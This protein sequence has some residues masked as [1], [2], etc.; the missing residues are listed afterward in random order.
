ME[1]MNHT[2]I[3]ST[4]FIFIASGEKEHNLT[5]RQIAAHFET[6]HEIHVSSRTISRRLGEFGLV[7]RHGSLFNSDHFNHDFIQKDYTSVSNII[8]R[9]ITVV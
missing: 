5:N 7:N 1:E 2:E 3:T 8:V 6:T 4:G 9:S